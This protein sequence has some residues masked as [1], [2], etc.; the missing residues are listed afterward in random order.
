MPS[1][2][3]SPE[4]GEPLGPLPR[5]FAAF[6]RP[7][8]P[9]LLNEIRA[10]VTRAYP[11]Y[12]RLFD[13][14]DGDAIRQGVEH[15]LAAFVDRVANPGQSSEPRDELLRRFGRV[16]AY[17]G[18]DLETLQGAYRLGARIALRRAKTVGRQH[19]LSPA[20]VLAFADALFAYVEELEAVTREG[21][22]EV[23]ERSASEVSAL[24][25]QLLHLILAAPPLPRATVSELCEAAA[26]ELPREC[27][28]VAL[29]PPVPHHIQ[30][31][32]DDDV[33]ADLDIPQPYLLLPGDLT[34]QRLT[35]LGTALAGT[36]AAVG[37]TVPLAQTADSV[38]WARRVLQ[39]VDDGVVPDAPLIPCADHLTTL[40]LLSDP[41]LVD[42]LAA[43]ELAPLGGLS[44]SRRDRLVETLRVHVSTRAPAE[45]VGEMLGVHAQTVRYRLRNLDGYL[46]DSLSDPDHR[47]ALE[48]ALRALHLRGR[49][50]Q[51]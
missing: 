35:M 14:P 36:R 30:A 43:R 41:A 18:R 26:W 31:G 29:R 49:A 8:L 3:R 11:V 15:T 24:R 10:E 46:G 34:P 9:G 50:G 27:T 40:W 44:P 32:L 5:Q 16:E 1:I 51:E 33:L 19:N 7:E 20:L 45:Q 42:H 25:R 4:A 17:E 12:G 37:L 28:L 48:A 39:L 21:Y 13:G 23:R 47:F 2:T 22:A 38:R 6:I